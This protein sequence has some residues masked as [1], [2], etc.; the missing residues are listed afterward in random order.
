MFFADT[1]RKRTVLKMP[2][3]ATFLNEL[4]APLKSFRLFAI[5]HFIYEGTGADL[6]QTLEQALE[7]ESDE[8]CRLL[9]GHAIASVKSRT[10]PSQASV[11][12]IT[13]PDT[14]GF[15][16]TFGAASP[17]EKLR[18][19]RALS[20]NQ[21]KDLAAWAVEA[22]RQENH[23][24]V[25]RDLIRRFGSIWPLARLDV[26]KEALVSNLQAVRFAAIEALMEL[27][28]QVLLEHIPSMLQNPDPRLRSL[29]IRALVAIDPDEARAH[30]EALLFGA[31]RYGRI[32]ALR[33][34]ARLPFSLTRPLLL[35]FLSI[36]PVPAL[37]DAAGAILAAN[38]DPEIPFRIAD[39]LSQRSDQ[40]QMLGAIL[41]TVISTL[42]AS[43]QLA[44]DPAIYRERLQKHVNRLGAKR[45][46]KT[47]QAA[48]SLPD[49]VF[50]EEA[51]AS[52]RLRLGQPAI[53]EALKELLEETMPEDVRAAIVDMLE[54]PSASPLEKD[55]PQPIST[56]AEPGS[57]KLDLASSRNWP[58]EASPEDQ[59]RWLSSR[60]REEADITA[61][62]IQGLLEKSSTP[63]QV[64]AVAFRTACRLAL[65]GFETAAEEGIR[66]TDD[67]VA[68]AAFDYLAAVSPDE[69]FPLLG[70]FLKSPR[71]RLRLA[72][73]K[74]LRSSDPLQAVSSLFTLLQSPN[75]QERALSMNCLVQFEFSLIRDS[76]VDLLT[77]GKAP[78]LC[79]SA[80]ALFEANPDLDSLYP[81]YQLAR[82]ENEA[83][84]RRADQTRSRIIDLLVTVGRATPQTIKTLEEGFPARLKQDNAR[85]AIPAPAYSLRSVKETPPPTAEIIRQML[86]GIFVTHGR[87]IV[88]ALVISLL[89]GRFFG[90]DGA[91]TEVKAISGAVIQSGIS[92]A[93]GSLAEIQAFGWTIRLNDGTRW[94][95]SPPPGGF[96]PAWIGASVT[97]EAAIYRRDTDGA[98]LG[99]C[100]SVV[101]HP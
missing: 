21:A 53:R 83:I 8:E 72:A 47:L 23:P 2:D 88:G 50:R 20:P 70:K 90:F 51:L 18:L 66:Q 79:D 65:P 64:R 58:A 57:P 16:G 95:L 15:P 48:F 97:V 60:S 91:K 71:P 1:L 14:T 26:L 4:N 46:V 19:L 31:D 81:L 63:P 32:A 30:L 27:A 89:L 52:L 84:A 33:E 73:I 76:L 87:W 86:Y 94:R 54:P 3:Q 55:R 11:V 25:A 41:H 7:N 12:N 78:E 24:L 42:H 36:E 9:L 17:E 45:A 22:F 80:F 68:A 75:V 92:R 62:V 10:A 101:I 38:P 40:G 98:L 77:S 67:A 82:N 96:P 6:V 99:H 43:G 37:L 29:L 44:E 49:T 85:R 34:C 56:V 59:A 93:S 69:V 100:R 35:T 39:I 13:L 28:P 5:E 61:E 74:I